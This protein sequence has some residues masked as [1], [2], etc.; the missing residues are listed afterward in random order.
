VFV[1]VK[2]EEKEKGLRMGAR[3]FIQNRL[4]KMS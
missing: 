4:M 3:G 1:T 2:E